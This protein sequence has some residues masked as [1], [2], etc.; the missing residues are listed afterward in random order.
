MAKLKIRGKDLIKLGYPEGRAIGM[1]VNMMLKHFKR[2]S[3]K[4]VLEILKKILEHPDL[5]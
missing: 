3:L 1:A 2:S 4:D 5:Y